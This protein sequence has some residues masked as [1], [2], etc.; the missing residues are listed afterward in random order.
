LNFVRDSVAIS[1]M[2]VRV[3]ANMVDFVESEVADGG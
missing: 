3:P 1:T 2:K